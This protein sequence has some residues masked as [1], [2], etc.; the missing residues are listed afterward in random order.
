MVGRGRS[1]SDT[2]MTSVTPLVAGVP[3][4]L[5]LFAGLPVTDT[6][7]VIRIIGDFKVFYDVTF[8]IGDSL[9]AVDVGI[10]VTSAEAFAVG[11]T[12][13]PSPIID[14]Q[15][16]PRGWL[17]ASTQAVLHILHGTEPAIHVVEAHFKFD[18]KAQRK[19]D[20]GVLFMTIEQNNIV[21]GGAMTVTGRVRALC[22]T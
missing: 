22:L 7:T 6:K 14:T 21:V 1:W 5:D 16:P 11:D 19:V 17:Y 3:R 12:A 10:G 4:H 20:K 18:L 9:S 15:F 8:T 13:L 2:R